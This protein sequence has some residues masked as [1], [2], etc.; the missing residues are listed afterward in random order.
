MLERVVKHEPR[1]PTPTVASPGADLEEELAIIMLQKVVR[2]R[3]LQTKVC[4]CVCVQYVLVNVCACVHTYVWLFCI[5]MYMFACV[6]VCLCIFPKLLLETLTIRAP[7][8]FCLAYIYYGYLP[9]GKPYGLFTDVHWW[10]LPFLWG[11]LWISKY[12]GNECYLD[13]L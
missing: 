7:C 3:A 6:R 12:F 13:D 4:V 1:P 5:G 2:G 10:P 11:C 8:F 9:T